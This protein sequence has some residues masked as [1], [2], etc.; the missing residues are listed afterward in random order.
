MKVVFLNCGSWVS[1]PAL[2]GVGVAILRGDSY[3]LVDCGPGV[4]ISISMCGLADLKPVAIVVTHIHGDHVLGLPTFLMWLRFRGIEH[5][6]KIVCTKPLL[7]SLYRLLEL[8]NAPRSD[9]IE[10]LETEP[11]N[12]V[13]VNGF[14]ISLYEARHTVYALAVKVCLDDH[15]IVYAC[16]T[17]PF[18]ELEE[19]AR[20]CD[21]LIHE[22]SGSREDIVHPIGHSTARDAIKIANRCRARLL[23]LLHPGLEPIVLKRGTSIESQT[24]V[25]YP[26]YE[27]RLGDEDLS[28][29][30]EP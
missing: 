2:G 28:T 17:A 26:C 15:C 16:D 10:F 19:I 12:E 30:S 20:N 24:I 25:P 4:P 8:V 3:V 27:V 11:G 18:N 29:P 22:C 14:K 23:A 5:R 1:P 6:V 7:D 13:E 9:V 21:M